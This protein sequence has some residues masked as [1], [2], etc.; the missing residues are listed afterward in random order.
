MR[1][2]NRYRR[3]LMRLRGFCDGAGARSMNPKHA[4]S[5]YETGYVAGQK[6]KSEY[7]EASAKELGVSVREIVPLLLSPYES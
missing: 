2:E 3:N 4:G 6:A 5:D 1:K 7:A